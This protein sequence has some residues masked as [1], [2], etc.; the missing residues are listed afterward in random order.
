MKTPSKGKTIIAFIILIIIVAG[1]GVSVWWYLTKYTQSFSYESFTKWDKKTGTETKE[2]QTNTEK[3]S[4]VK[5]TNSQ[6]GFELTFPDSWKDYGVME[7]IFEGETKTIYFGLPKKTPTNI[8]NQSFIDYYDSPFAISIFTKSQW[9]T[10]QSQEFA[11]RKITENDN[12]VFAYSQG[13]GV[14]DIA[15]MNQEQA[16]NDIETIIN[17]FKFIK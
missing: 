7:V 8:F 14:L 5:Y 11:P 6:F 2:E 4:G 3:T 1:V 9:T 12:Y 10:A 15:G 16:Y 17:T 13:N